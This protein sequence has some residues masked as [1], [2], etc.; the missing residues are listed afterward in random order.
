MFAGDCRLEAMDASLPPQRPGDG[1]HLRLVS[2]VANA[3]RDAAGEIDAF[4][5][6]EKPV[7]EM[8]PRLLAI[9]HDVDPG[10]LLQL[11]HQYR[12]VALCFY[13]GFA[14]EPPGRPQ[15]L[16]R[17]EPGRFWQTACDRRFEHR[18]TPF[19]LRSYPAPAMTD[20]KR[21]RRNSP[22]APK[23]NPKRTRP[24]MAQAWH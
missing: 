6:F 12:R 24:T 8:L 14:G 18:D 21:V 1:R 15:H 7:H 4:D 17:G 10:V 5:V 23:S 2:V 9:G 11:H 3:H 16:W 22:P 13:Q 20:I 19:L